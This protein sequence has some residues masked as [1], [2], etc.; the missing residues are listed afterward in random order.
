MPD[1]SY[2]CGCAYALDACPCVALVGNGTNPLLG[3][4]SDG[5]ICVS[6]TALDSPHV[7]HVLN[8]RHTVMPLAPSVIKLAR[9]FFDQPWSGGVRPG[10]EGQHGKLLV[11]AKTAGGVSTAVIPPDRGTP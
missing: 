1:R 11:E 3:T 2:W 5:V 8:V 6:E 4:P 10:A 7:R 9:D